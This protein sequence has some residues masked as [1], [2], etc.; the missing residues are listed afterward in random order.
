MNRFCGYTESDFLESIIYL[1]TADSDNFPKITNYVQLKNKQH[2]SKILLNNFPMKGHTMQSHLENSGSERVNVLDNAF[3]IANTLICVLFLRS[4][5]ECWK[6]VVQ[7]GNL[8]EK[9]VGG[10]AGIN[11]YLSKD[12]TLVLR[13]KRR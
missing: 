8:L 6:I 1:S 7:R 12:T 4:M 2:H 13:D 5:T 3:L 10:Q 11:Q 9:R